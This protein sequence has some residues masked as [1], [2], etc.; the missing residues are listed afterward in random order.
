MRPVAVIIPDELAQQA[1]K[2]ILVED[3]HVIEQFSTA[4]PDPAFGHAVLQRTLVS[5]PQ[6]PDSNT[7][8]RV[9]DVDR[10]NRV[11]IEQKEAR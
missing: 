3:D 2:V 8:N 10:E 4:S 11:V 1:A 5:G 9:A 6:R 7:A